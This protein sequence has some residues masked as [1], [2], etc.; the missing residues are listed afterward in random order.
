MFLMEVATGVR[1]SLRDITYLK[2]SIIEDTDVADS[3]ML[4]LLM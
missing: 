2:N 3:A 4:E 1:F